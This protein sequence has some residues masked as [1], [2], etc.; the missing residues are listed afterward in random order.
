MSQFRTLELS[1]PACTPPGLQFITVKSAAL[2]R[3]ANI[4]LWTPP[5]AESARDLPLV[6]LLH[7]VFGSAWAWAFKG[8]AHGIASAM[9]ESGEIPPMAIAMPSDGL[10]GDGSGYACHADADYERWIMEEV[11]AA[12]AEVLPAISADSSLAISGLS[13]GGFGAMRLGARHADRL[14]AISAHSAVTRLADIAQFVEE[15]AE[16]F[17]SPPDGDLID[18]LRAAGSGLPPL[19]FD[20]GVGDELLPAN[21]LLHRQLS[22]AGIPHTYEE[23]PGAHTWAYWQ[24]HLPAALRFI[25]DL[26]TRQS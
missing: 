2:G 16:A 21:Q 14:V 23:H 6:L 18:A 8:N 26:A 17:P 24:R 7:G 3:R 13:M 25:G 4:T 9:V 1:D 10:W 11:P 22:E 12:V 15:P 19:R 5:A 20:C